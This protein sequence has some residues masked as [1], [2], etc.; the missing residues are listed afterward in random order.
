MIFIYLVTN[1]NKNWQMK[2][3]ER[4]ILTLRILVRATS[5]REVPFTEMETQ[6]GCQFVWG[7]FYIEFEMSTRCSSEDDW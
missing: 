7:L 6:K 3:R 5:Y 4:P 2:E 1:I